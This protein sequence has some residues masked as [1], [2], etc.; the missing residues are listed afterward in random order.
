MSNYDLYTCEGRMYNSGQIYFRYEVTSSEGRK[1][2][3]HPFK[4]LL[5]GRETI[6]ISYLDHCDP[7]QAG[8]LKYRLFSVQKSINYNKHIYFNL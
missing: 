5:K 2:E 8:F 7:N 1:G 6:I 4:P 3:S